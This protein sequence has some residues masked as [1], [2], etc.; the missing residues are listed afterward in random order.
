[1]SF[2]GY[3]ENGIVVV[4]NR[5]LARHYVKSPEFKFDVIS[6]LPTDLLYLAVGIHQP[7]VRFNR[8]LRWQRLTEFFDRTIRRTG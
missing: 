1:M 5:M 7:A 4:E 2:S 3:L 6:I 8:L